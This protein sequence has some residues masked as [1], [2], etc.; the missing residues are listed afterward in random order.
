M[1]DLSVSGQILTILITQKQTHMHSWRD[2]ERRVQSKP[3][4]HMKK[5]LQPKREKK[6]TKKLKF[7]VGFNIFSLFLSQTFICC[8]KEEKGNSVIGGGTCGRSNERWWHTC[9]NRLDG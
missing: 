9:G 3:K 8:T 7:V 5:K 4:T 6:K 1:D 2:R